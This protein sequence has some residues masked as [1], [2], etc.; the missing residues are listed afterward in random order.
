ME[1]RSL[2]KQV[3]IQQHNN[4]SIEKPIDLVIVLRFLKNFSY[5]SL[6]MLRSKIP[7]NGAK[8]PSKTSVK[9]TPQLASIL[10]PIWLHFGRVLGAKLEPRSHQIAPQVDPK[11]DQKNDHLLDGSWDRFWLILAPTWGGPGGSVGGPSGYF[12]A[13]FWL[14]GPSWPPD[15]PRTPPRGLLGPSKKPLGIDF[16]FHFEGFWMNLASHFVGFW[17]QLDLNLSPNQPSSQ[18]AN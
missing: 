10:E 7:K 8:I 2:P 16:A 4:H 1:P 18:P 15:P 3:S 12:L 17:C 14:L 5:S 9:S 13:T 6:G 11:N